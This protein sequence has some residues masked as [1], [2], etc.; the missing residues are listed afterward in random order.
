MIAGGATVAAIAVTA[1]AYAT[2]LST[3]NTFNGA[4]PEN[5][6]SLKSSYNGYRTVAY[7]S[8]GASITLAAITG[9]LTAWYLLG[10][11]HSAFVAPAVTPTAGA[12]PGAQLTLVGQ[13]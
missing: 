5:Q 7:V 3:Q 12:T 1:V 4:E 10:T 13:F 11:K 8:L 9:G 2:A 6:P